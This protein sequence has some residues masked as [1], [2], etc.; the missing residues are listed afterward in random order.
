M[1]SDEASQSPDKRIKRWRRFNDKIAKPSIRGVHSHRRLCRSQTGRYNIKGNLSDQPRSQRNGIPTPWNRKSSLPMSHESC[2]SS[3]PS[4][5]IRQRPHQ[6]RLYDSII[7]LPCAA[8]HQTPIDRLFS[9]FRCQPETSFIVKTSAAY[10]L[11]IAPFTPT[12]TMTIECRMLWPCIKTRR[13]A[14]PCRAQ[15]VAYCEVTY[16]RY[17]HAYT[18]F[19]IS[20][21]RV[22]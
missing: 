3:F 7:L 12:S 21:S 22:S 5:A 10:P 18:P 9:I 17:A 13:G 6:E 2:S 19:V 14:W 15:R 1:N 4:V 20:Y 8:L 16:A 11:A